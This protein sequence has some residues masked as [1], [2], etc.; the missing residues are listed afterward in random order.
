MPVLR[1]VFSYLNTNNYPLTTAVFQGS[2]FR[3][4]FSG[5][6]DYQGTGGR[7]QGSVVS[8]STRLRRYLES[9]YKLAFAGF[10]SVFSPDEKRR[11]RHNEMSYVEPSRRSMAENKPQ[12]RRNGVNRQTLNMGADD[13]SAC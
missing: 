8:Y 1:L 10:A 9:V 5:N 7:G 12:S 2:V 4:Q 13:A 6:R 11:R 3:D